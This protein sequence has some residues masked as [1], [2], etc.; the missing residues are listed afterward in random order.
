MRGRVGVWAEGRGAGGGLHHQRD[1]GPADTE[2]GKR[3]R[4]KGVRAQHGRRRDQEQQRD[5]EV[6]SAHDRQRAAELFPHLGLVE[7]A[8]EQ[9]VDAQRAVDGDGDDVGEEERERPILTVRP[10]A[11][12]RP[13]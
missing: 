13:P 9:Q 4:E 6:C 12:A 8:R 5:E 3:R 1:D 11:R 7:R 2:R 10:C